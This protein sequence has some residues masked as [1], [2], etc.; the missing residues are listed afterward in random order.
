[1]KPHIK[2][3]NWDAIVASAAL[4]TQSATVTSGGWESNTRAEPWLDDANWQ[5]TPHDLA[6]PSKDP[7]FIDMTGKRI[8]R[9]VIQGL[10]VKKKPNKSG[11]PLWSVRCDCGAHFA[12]RARTLRKIDPAKVMCQRCD[13]HEGIKRGHSPVALDNSHKPRVKTFEPPKPLPKRPLGKFAAAIQKIIEDDA[14]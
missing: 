9:G 11:N 3:S 6:P 7:M 14:A 13:Y 4:D 2:K 1:M 10:M 12:M 8:G 5:E